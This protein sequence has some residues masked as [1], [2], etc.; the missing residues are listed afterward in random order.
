M[1]DSDITDVVQELQI[2]EL[3]TLY[4]QLGL[5]VQT[6]ENE[7]VSAG[8]SDPKLRATRVLQRWRQMNGQSAS[9]QRILYALESCKF[10]QTKQTLERKW[11]S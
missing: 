9:R 2:A 11:N 6:V 8:V 10:R 5:T 7:E 3:K 1:S 4:E